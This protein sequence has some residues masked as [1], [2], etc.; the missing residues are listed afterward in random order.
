MTTSHHETNAP[1]EIVVG[2]ILMN[3]LLGVGATC[4][5]LANFFVDP[6]QI[7]KRYWIWLLSYRIKIIGDAG[8][9]VDPSADA[10]YGLHALTK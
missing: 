2:S 6:F 9:P 8:R 1:F 4:E 7:A 3:L 5:N 10:E